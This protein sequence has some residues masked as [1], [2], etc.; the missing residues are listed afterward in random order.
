[1]PPRKL[2]NNLRELGVI[3]SSSRVS[4]AVNVERINDYFD[5][6]PSSSGQLVLQAH[7]I[8]NVPEFSSINVDSNEVSDAVLISIKSNAAGFDEIPMSFIRVLLPVILPALTPNYTFPC[9]EFP[10]QWKTSVVLPIPI[11]ANPLNFSDFRPLK[12]AA[13]FF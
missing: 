10:Q 12:F 1:L 4:V 8:M 3:N 11:V 2:Y 9:S 5:S 6:R 7:S 13:S